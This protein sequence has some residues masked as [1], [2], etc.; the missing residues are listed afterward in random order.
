MKRKLNPC[1]KCHHVGYDDTF[2]E[3]VCGKNSRLLGYSI[4]PY[5]WH[6]CD[7]IGE[8]GDQREIKAMFSWLEHEKHK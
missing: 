8:D 1:G 7:V 4:I 3:W 6:G 5:K 2:S